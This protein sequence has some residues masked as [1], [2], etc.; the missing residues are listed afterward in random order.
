MPACEACNSEFSKLEGL[1]KECVVGL[2]ARQPLPAMAYIYLLNWLDKVRIGYW[3]NL[4][5]LEKF[6]IETAPNFYIKSRIGRKDRMVGI[7]TFDTDNMGLNI[8]GADSMIFRE[9]PSCFA[10]RIN[11]IMLI[12]ASSDYFCSERCGFPY[13]SRIEVIQGGSWDGM[14]SLSEFKI[15]RQ[16]RHPLLDFAWI[17]PAVLLYQSIMTPSKDPR[18]QSGYLGDW[19]LHDSF[20]HKHRLNHGSG[21]GILYRQC[22]D[23]VQSI[24]SLQNL[25]ELDEVNGEDSKSLNEIVAQGYDFQIY[26]RK[27]FIRQTP[28]YE[29]HDDPGHVSREAFEKA[30]CETT[31]GLADF[32]RRMPETNTLTS[33]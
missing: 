4:K 29:V 12:N 5:S 8:F 7:Y 9:M 32:Y 24:F 20:L 25:V 31:Q 16:V 22:S 21:Q 33:A 17:K 15:T 19:N 18:W 26:L 13:P 6:P 27:K 10:L 2:L 30:T 11:N 23:R 1:A 28:I 14:L 3:L